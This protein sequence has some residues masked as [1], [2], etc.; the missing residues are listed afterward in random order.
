MIS[1]YRGDVCAA[2]DGSSIYTNDG[3]PPNTTDINKCGK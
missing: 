2:K 1:S 3:P